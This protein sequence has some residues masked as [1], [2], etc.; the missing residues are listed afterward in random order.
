MSLHLQN[1]VVP[2]QLIATSEGEGEGGFLRGHGTFIDHS[3]S[4]SMDNQ[5]NENAK[6]SS[7]GMLVDVTYNGEIEENEEEKLQLN[8]KEE[9]LN[10]CVCGTVE[11]VNKLISVIPFSPTTYS[12]QVGDLVIG[13]IV[14]VGSTRWRVSLGPGCREAVLPLS[15]VN[16][17]SGIQ[18]MR[19][20]EDALGMRQLYRE[21]DLLSAE[22][23]QVSHS[24]GVLHLHARSLKYGKL[25]S[26]LVP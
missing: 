7:S 19:T 2:G 11:R 16:L 26:N 14:S 20:S 6:S 21:G 12:G 5:K 23:Q 24:D 25:V 22:V 4:T 15:G 9:H 17:P 13:R 3:N 18:R 8:K 1:I 10:A